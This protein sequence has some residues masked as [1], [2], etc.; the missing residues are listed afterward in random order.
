MARNADVLQV[1]VVPDS[2][3]IPL[4]TCL[5]LEHVHIKNRGRGW[6]TSLRGQPTSPASRSTAIGNAMLDLL[7]VASSSVTS[8]D[9]STHRMN[10][11]GFFSQCTALMS[12]W[13]TELMFNNPS[14][15]NSP[16]SDFPPFAVI[17]PSRLSP[18]QPP[19]LIPSPGVSIKS[20]SH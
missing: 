15:R 12:H 3:L 4:A 6:I 11:L 2:Q 17:F 5:K 10:P 19:V 13:A 7:N 1:A 14:W 16:S 18:P 8:M 9:W 20:Y